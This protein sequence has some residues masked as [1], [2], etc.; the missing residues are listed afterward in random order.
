MVEYPAPLDGNEDND[1]SI[2]CDKHGRKPRIEGECGF[3]RID[4][5]GINAA[6]KSIQDNKIGVQDLTRRSNENR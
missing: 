3:C 2:L 6:I 4:R 5:I 1:F